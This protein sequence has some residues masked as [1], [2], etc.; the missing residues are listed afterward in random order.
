MSE[1]KSDT[2]KYIAALDI[3]TTSIRCFI[4]DTNVQIKGKAFEKVIF[5]SISFLNQL[6]RLIFL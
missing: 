6:F 5:L 2:T 1:K 3:G 4:Y